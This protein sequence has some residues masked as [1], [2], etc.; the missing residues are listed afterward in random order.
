MFAEPGS[1]QPN[2][3]YCFFL[4]LQTALDS[5][6][7]LALPWPFE[8]QEIDADL[9]LAHYHLHRFAD[10]PVQWRDFPRFFG[11]WP[12]SNS[13]GSRPPEFLWALMPTPHPYPLSRKFKRVPK[14]LINALT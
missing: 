2:G 1:R 10:W 5:G 6:P 14:E 4:Q 7:S 13:S 9:L 11:W 3:D 8:T 12:H